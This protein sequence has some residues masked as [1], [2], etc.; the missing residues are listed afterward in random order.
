[1][2]QHKGKVERGVGYAKDNALKGRKFASLSEQNAHLLHWEGQVADQRIH[3]T[4]RRQVA[5]VFE[6]ERKVLR[7]LPASLY[8]VYREARR[9]VGRD[10]FVEVDKAYYEAPPEYIGRQV[11]VR[12][13][14]RMVRL[15][16]ERGEQIACHARLEPGRF[17]RSLGVGGLHGTVKE[18]SDY[19]QSRAEVL[20]EAA[21]CWAKRALEQRGPEAIRSIMGLCKLTTK[22]PATAINAACAKAIDNQRALPSLRMVKDLLAAGN[23]APGQIQLELREADPIIRPLSDYNDYIRSQTAGDASDPNTPTEPT[24]PTKPHTESK[25]S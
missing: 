15:L 13:D 4:T 23:K 14:G 7:P 11:L 21:G 25:V 2:P 8:E 17:S 12:W 18:S 20:G 22:S 6:E 9:R 10:S 3:G 16:N 5:A 24:E 19:W 1:M